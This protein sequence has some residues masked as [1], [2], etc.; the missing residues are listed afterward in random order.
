MQLL[1]GWANPTDP[2]AFGSE[3]VTASATFI[4]RAGLSTEGEITMELTAGPIIRE[5]N[6][7]ALPLEIEFREGAGSISA[8][9]L[10]Q[11]LNGAQD[12]A[13][14]QARLFDHEA[15]TVA[16][17]ARRDNGGGEI[18]SFCASTREDT[19]F[20]SVEAGETMSW[21]GIFAAPEGDAASAL[22]REFGLVTAL[23]ETEVA[24]E[25]PEPCGPVGGADE[26]LRVVNGGRGPEAG[27]E[28]DLTVERVERSSGC[29]PLPLRR[30]AGH[31]CRQRVEQPSDERTSDDASGDE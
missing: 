15:M 20:C 1:G 27:T 9:D 19:S 21:T 13:G 14:G 2:A 30:R 3:V 24:G 5:D 26:T 4:P 10:C 22:L 18:A 11:G 12:H 8:L 7:V 17:L 29:P 16:E 28:L 23:E 31:R 6:L 25:L